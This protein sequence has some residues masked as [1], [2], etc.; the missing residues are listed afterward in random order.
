M[1]KHLMLVSL[2]LTA[3][4]FGGCVSVKTWDGQGRLLGKCRAVG[5]GK[6]LGC[7]GSANA[8]EGGKDVVLYP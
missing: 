3:M 5:L 8:K 4:L 2:F 7:V 6:G 1:N